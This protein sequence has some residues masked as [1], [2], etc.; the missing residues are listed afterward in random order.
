M[1]F[2]KQLLQ[3]GVEFEECPPPRVLFH[4]TVIIIALR[5]NVDGCGETFD[6]S[7]DPRLS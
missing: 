4:L 5:W 2:W 7:L 1:D 6:L 3:Y